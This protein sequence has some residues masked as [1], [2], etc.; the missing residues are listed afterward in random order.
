MRHAREIETLANDVVERAR[1]TGKRIPL[2]ASTMIDDPDLR[3]RVL[4][5]L[6]SRGGRRTQALKRMGKEEKEEEIR[7]HPRVPQQLNLSMTSSQA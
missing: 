7:E 3:R 4:R 2:L 1:A 6:G 5:H